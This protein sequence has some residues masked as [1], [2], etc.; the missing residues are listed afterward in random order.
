[1]SAAVAEAFRHMVGPKNHMR[2][3]PIAFLDV[4]STKVCCYV[5]RRRGVRGFTLLGRGYQ[6]SEGI[7]RGAV[8]DPDAIEDAI[9]AAVSEAE[10]QAGITIREIAVALSGCDPRTRLVQQSLKLSGRSVTEDDLHTLL[11]Q[12]SHNAREQGRQSLHIMPL[13]LQI[14]DGRPLKDPCG[15]SGEVLQMTASVISVSD[16]LLEE[17]LGCVRRSHLE[18]DEVIISSFAAGK[19]CL[20]PE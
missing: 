4:G 18:I 20:A 12:A 16:R 11:V 17:V 19:A 14:D 10:T 3:D 5:A 8:S 2:A 1:M 13:V 15:L 6:Q 7:E 9:Q